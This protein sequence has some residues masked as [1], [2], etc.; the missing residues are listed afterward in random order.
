MNDPARVSTPTYS[1]VS[2]ISLIPNSLARGAHGLGRNRVDPVEQVG[3]ADLMREHQGGLRAVS[4]QGDMNQSAQRWS[5]HARSPATRQ[6]YIARPFEKAPIRP[7][8][9][10]PTDDL[11]TSWPYFGYPEGATGSLL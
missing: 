3:L 6:T 11:G 8:K 4:D 2:L 5:A 10:K 1:L 9:R 7:E